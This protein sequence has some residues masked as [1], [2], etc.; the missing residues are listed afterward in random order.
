[1]FTLKISKFATYLSSGKERIHIR[2]SK[3]P[4]ERRTKEDIG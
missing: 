4:F 3:N 1:M 2:R